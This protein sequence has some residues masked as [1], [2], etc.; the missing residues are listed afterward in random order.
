MLAALPAVA[1]CATPPPA[2]TVESVA[3]P[4]RRAW[5]NGRRVD[6][7][8]T[9]VSDGA[10]A[11]A[12]QVNLVP[13]LA[14]A[15]RPVPAGQSLVERVYMFEREAQ[16]NVFPSA[17]QPVGARNG[18][19]GYSPLWR[20]VLVRWV[21]TAAQRELRSEE[22]ILAAAERGDVALE[23]TGIV[24]NCPVVRDADGQALGGVR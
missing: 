2:A 5:M 23:V 3:L 9:D 8:T 21:R 10:M 1:A 4:L 24:A 17:P 18:D 19:S 11:A 7:V 6:Y 14:Q 22:A 16:I 15:L 13:R 12:M 20:I